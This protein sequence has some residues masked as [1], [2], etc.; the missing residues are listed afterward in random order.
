MQLDQLK[1]IITG[2]RGMGGHFAKRLAE[3]GAKV[4]VGDVD[5]EALDA[6]PPGIVKRRLDVSDSAQVQSFVE[7]AAEQM[8]GLNGLINN[9]GILRDGLLVK[10]DRKTGEIKSMSDDNWRK[11]L[12]VNLDGPTFM[13]RAV[14][15]QMLKT[16][17][18]PGV[19]VNISSISRHGNR[20]QSN[21]VAAKAALAANTVTWAREFARYGIRVGAIAPGMVA[22]P[23][24]DGMNEKAREALVA[25]I[26]VGRIGQPE[27]IWLAAKFV[28]ECGYFNGKT[29][30]VDGGGA[31]G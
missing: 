21:Y 12:A 25:S 8:R 16:E 17:T 1:I 9:A 24:T 19:I 22:T 6:L 27:D 10:R 5:E 18:R 3:A 11:V 31:M 13:T 26:P 23:M 4:A 30:D 7:W 2:G 29:I 20:G 15:G 14:V 28:L